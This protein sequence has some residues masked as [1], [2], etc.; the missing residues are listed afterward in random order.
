MVTI[1]VDDQSCIK[2]CK[3]VKVCPSIIFKQDKPQSKIETH[4][5]DHCIVCG[6]CV[7]VCPTGS[8]IHSAFP[9]DKVHA[10]NKE[11]LPSADQV[12]TLIKSRRSYRTFSKK[13][14]P[15][16]YLDQILDAAHSA[17]TAENYQQVKYTLITDPKVL[18]QVSATTISIFSSLIKKISI[19]KPLIKRF[20]P[21]GYAEISDLQSLIDDFSN[22]KDR[23]LRGA[24]ALIL[25]HTPKDVRFGCQDSNLA[26][27]NGS[28]MAQSLGVGQFYTGYICAASSMSRNNAIKRLL[29]IDGTIHAGMALGMQTLNYPNY[30]D[31]KDIDL[32]RF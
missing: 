5:I 21:K 12:M 24:T 3:C 28:L 22:N 18:H 17:P 20:Y 1:E 7:A 13:P 16:E 25:I 27:Q 10:L 19:V 30:A 32:K 26:Y 29:E 4:H 11:L 23:I 6:Q 9:E 31:K 14:I 8:V 15:S 2:C